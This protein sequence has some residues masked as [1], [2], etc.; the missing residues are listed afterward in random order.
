[1]KLPENAG[2]KFLRT[3]VVAALVCAPCL[4]PAE[5]ASPRPVII[6]QPASMKSEPGTLDISHGI[7]IVLPKADPAAA[8]AKAYL[9]SL[10]AKQPAFALAEK[11]PVTLRFEHRASSAESAQ[12][13]ESYSLRITPAGATILASSQAGYLYGAITFWQI[14]QSS[15]KQVGAVEIEDQP[16]FRW[17]GFMLDSA[18]HIQSEAFIYQL[19]DYMALHKM[20]VFHWHL[21]DDQG[22]RIEIKKYPRLTQVGGFRG[23]IMPPYQST[24]AIKPYG[25]YFSQQ[26]IRAI[27]AYAQQRNIT[28]VPEIEMPG[29]STAAIAAYPELS[30]TSTPPTGPAT[31]WG[32]FPN[33][34]NVDDN[35]FD[36]IQN[37][38]LEV[39]QLF[40]SHY[41]HIGGDEAIKNQ[42]KS[43]PKVQARMRELGIK[44]EDAM[45]SWF[46]GRIEKFLNA[47]G[48]SMVGWDEI[49]QGGLSPNATVMS[50]RGTEGG[51]AAAKQN[52]DVVMTPSRPLYFNYRQSDS[53]TEPPGRVP[54]NALRDIYN[55]NIAIDSLTPEQFRHVLGVEA[56]MWSE[57][58]LPTENVEH[59]LFPRLAALSELAWTPASQKDYSSFLKRLP[60]E[61]DRDKAAHL[62]PAESV[63]EVRTDAKLSQDGTSAA[64]HLST[65]SDIAQIRYTLD[66]S[67]VSAASPLYG[68]PFDAPLA[69]SLTAQAFMDGAPVGQ[70]TV[71]PLTLTNILR[72]DARELDA[73]ETV[74]Q[75]QIE[76]DPPRNA[77]R[78]VFR[79]SYHRPCWIDRAVPMDLVQKMDIQVGSMPDIFATSMKPVTIAAGGSQPDPR[80][81]V[82]VDRCDGQLLT[83]IDARSAVRK[84]GVITLHAP[85][86]AS[87]HG[88]HDLCFDFKSSDPNTSWL[89]HAIE[90]MPR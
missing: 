9:L 41:I 14:A 44:D 56:C 79:V 60:V 38:L 55:F 34:Y 58:I 68:A 76:Q 40:P 19:L 3:V 49:L 70:P 32:I 78:P 73:C 13:D 61:L 74:A 22:W 75:M 84:D 62:R 35:T 80:V 6:P 7:R 36:F 31:G 72:R 12:N 16:R 53:A 23:P 46:V 29:H 24:A 87:V 4:S 21:V 83:S 11:A 39:M 54:V 2:A 26:Q 82:Y 89:M 17:R 63:F 8:S 88:T 28:I 18:R 15:G 85:E 45:Q 37:V 5:A 10:N 90:P 66:G 69:H 77:E 43:N 27:V 47:H 52:H 1:M 48:R 81:D 42:W 67:P 25:G 65:Q 57:F 50:W 86:L 64:F 20:N 59:M 71:M 51:I 30:S 33:L